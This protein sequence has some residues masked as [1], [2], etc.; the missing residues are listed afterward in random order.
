MDLVS[1]LMLMGAIASILALLVVLVSHLRRRKARLVVEPLNV[2]RDLKLAESQFANMKWIGSGQPGVAD[3]SHSF[4]A[5]FGVLRVSCHGGHAFRCGAGVRFRIDV[6][7]YDAESGRR[8]VTSVWRD[9]GHL[10]WYSPTLRQNLAT[11]GQF[12]V[13][14]LTRYIANTTEDLR[15]GDARSP[16]VLRTRRKPGL[17]PLQRYGRTSVSDVQPGRIDE[18]P[19]GSNLHGRWY[20]TYNLHVRRHRFLGSHLNR[21]VRRCPSDRSRRAG[22]GCGRLVSVTR[23][24]I[25]SRFRGPGP[26]ESSSAFSRGGGGWLQFGV[27]SNWREPEAFGEVGVGLL[28]GSPEL[29]D[30]CRI[31]K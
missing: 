16:S 9:G 19:S 15:D 3:S 13:R 30:L 8:F 20:G 18:G 31:D 28:K 12:D 21:A 7:S 22:L 2:A 14:E 11:L 26:R 25:A 29:G 23:T 24:R 17:V 10:N 6:P 5:W 1:W 27:V 4:S